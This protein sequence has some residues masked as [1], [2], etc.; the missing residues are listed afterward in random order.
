MRPWT[1]MRRWLI[2]SETVM[3]VR[4]L[5]VL[6][7]VA[8]GLVRAVENIDLTVNAGE[9]VALVGESG[10]GKS[11]TGLSMM[12]LLQSPPAIW[13]ADKIEYTDASGKVIDITTADESVLEKLR[14]SEISMIYQDPS[15]V[16]Y[17]E[18]TVIHIERQAYEKGRNY[19]PEHFRVN[20]FQEEYRLCEEVR[21]VKIGGHAKGSCIVEVTIDGK[22]YV[23]CGD[24]CYLHY[25][26]TNH[27]PT[28]K[29]YSLERSQYFI[30]K[31]SDS[32]FICLLS[33][34][35]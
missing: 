34:E 25:N 30:D 15:S 2:M 5:K 24:E 26:L 31:Y 13:R 1:I 33:H 21:I 16:H 23:L 6:F 35:E 9:C 19:I 22:E 18:N 27:I 11:V 32:R 28:A 7:H 17:F 14:G 4:G 10:C 3:K 8:D 20:V 29:R 12:R